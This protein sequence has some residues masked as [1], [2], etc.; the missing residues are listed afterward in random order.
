MAVFISTSTDAFGTTREEANRRVRRHAPNVRRPLR[1]IQVKPNTYANLRVLTAAGHP[2]ELVDSGSTTVTDEGIGISESYANFMIQSLRESRAEKQ[3][4]IET[5]GED[6][7]FFFGERPRFLEVTGILINTADFN[8]KSEFWTNYENYL[9]GTKLVELNA[10]LYFHFDDLVVEGYMMGASTTEDASA[11]HLLPLQFQIYITNYAVLSKPGS[12]YFDPSDTALY[13][14]D[15][16]RYNAAAALKPVPP[17]TTAERLAGQVSGAGGL[18][19]FLARTSALSNGGFSIQSTLEALRNTLYARALVV[20]AGLDAQ[21]ASLAYS[22][23]VQNM[24]AFE[25]PP[26]FRPIHEMVDEY[27]ERDPVKADANTRFAAAQEARRIEMMLRKPEDLDAHARREF[28]KAGIDTGRPNAMMALL[29]R[30]AFAAV[31][32]TAPFAL[33]KIGGGVIGRVDQ[34]VKQLPL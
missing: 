30:G 31:Q 28:E 27:V 24:G 13:S 16:E 1:G 2:I 6:Y 22:P 3:Q 8:W 14:Y 17:D 7:V 23:P 9:R 12:V 5:F 32:Y 21:G 25:S 33:S 34:A 26:Q 15:P 10:R 18:N 19:A 4:I 29:G 11:R 20:P